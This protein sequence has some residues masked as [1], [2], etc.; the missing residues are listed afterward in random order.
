[1]NGFVF[2]HSE[3]LALG[4]LSPEID[5]DRVDR[6]PNDK[7]EDIEKLDRISASRKDTSIDFLTHEAKGNQQ[8]ARV[9]WDSNALDDKDDQAEAL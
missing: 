5:F 1:V 6:S 4:L 8:E 2:Y 9:E 7:E 3:D